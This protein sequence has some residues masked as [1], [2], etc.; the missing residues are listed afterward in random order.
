[1]QEVAATYGAEGDNGGEGVDAVVDG[2][3]G[4]DGRFPLNGNFHC[5]GG[6]MLATCSPVYVY[7]GSREARDPY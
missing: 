3:G 7:M 1:M 2:V 4:E 6:G 5:W